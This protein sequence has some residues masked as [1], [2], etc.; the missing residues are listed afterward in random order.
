[1]NIRPPLEVDYFGRQFA[2]RQESYL[3]TDAIGFGE[4]RQAIRRGGLP[5]E[6]VI[7]SLRA[8]GLRRDTILADGENL[9]GSLQ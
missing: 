5:A 8:A 9:P 3:R 4:F 7:S 2:L 1:M 6:V